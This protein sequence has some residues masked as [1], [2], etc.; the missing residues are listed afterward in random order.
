MDRAKAGKFRMTETVCEGRNLLLHSEFFHESSAATGIADS[1]APRLYRL[2]DR[3]PAAYRR[4][5]GSQSRTFQRIP[6]RRLR[7]TGN[8]ETA[9]R[10]LHCRSRCNTCHKL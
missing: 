1:R 10:A 5:A 7:M 2:A 4:I 3:S 8:S 6:C 9:A